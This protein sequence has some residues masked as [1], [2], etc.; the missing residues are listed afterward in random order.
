[1]ISFTKKTAKFSRNKITAIALLLMLS[2]TA[3]L[4]VLPPADAAV[5]Y[6]HSY[7][8]VSTGSNVVGVGQQI[9]LVYWTADLP[10]D[11]GEIKGTVE[12]YLGRASWSGCSFNV[13]TPEGVT[14]KYPMGLSDSIGGGY[15][16]YT[17]TTVGTYTLTASFPGA[18]K[19]T[20]TSQRYYSAVDSNPVTFEVQQDQIP[21]W[22]E[23]PLCFVTPIAPTVICDVPVRTSAPASI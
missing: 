12:G 6:Y 4:V 9:L 5:N 21:S 11:I 19:N 7:M 1:M 2:M 16:T 23:S 14:T 20:T 22:T 3:S 17:P 13:T 18:W 15:M 8:Y 10:P